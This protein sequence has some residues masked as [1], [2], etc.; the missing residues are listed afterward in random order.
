MVTSKSA[1]AAASAAACIG[2]VGRGVVQ[3]AVCLHV[4]HAGAGRTGDR[5]QCA[6]L[7]QHVRGQILRCDVDAAAAEPG[8]VP[9]A[10]LRPDRDAP[11]RGAAGKC[12]A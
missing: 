11:F 10:D 12:A 4:T 5:G 9:V 1:T 3:S 7:V 8:E 2:V 6:E